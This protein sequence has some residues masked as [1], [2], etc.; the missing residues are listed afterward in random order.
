MRVGIANEHSWA[1]IAE[2]GNEGVV[3]A[4]SITEETLD[5]LLLTELLY[6]GYFARKVA[7][8]K[9]GVSARDDANLRRVEYAVCTRTFHL[10]Y[11]QRG[12]DVIGHGQIHVDGDH[13]AHANF[14][15]T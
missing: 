11:C 9:G 2:L 14:F 10:P 13:I 3:H 8:A 4:F 12:S 5:A 7:V 1:Y 15:A 6:V